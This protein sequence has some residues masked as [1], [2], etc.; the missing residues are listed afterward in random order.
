MRVWQKRKVSVFSFVHHA[1]S[2]TKATKHRKVSWPPWAKSRSCVFFT[3]ELIAIRISSTH[4]KDVCHWYT[5]QQYSVNLRVHAVTFHHSGVIPYQENSSQTSIATVYTN[6]SAISGKY[7]QPLDQKYSGNKQSLE[8]CW[9]PE[10]TRVF[11]TFVHS[12][13][14]TEHHGEHY[15]TDITYITLIVENCK[16]LTILQFPCLSDSGK[17]FC[18]NKM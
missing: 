18:Q 8:S 6:K 16:S 2:F 7:P 14:P 1:P 4:D 3:T 12:L 11:I 10:V 9:C 17:K 5:N 13:S 15:E